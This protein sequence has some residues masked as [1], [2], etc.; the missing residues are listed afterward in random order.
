Q[1]RVAETQ[2]RLAAESAQAAEAEQRALA[3]DKTQEAEAERDRAET[4]TLLAQEQTVLALANSSKA[5][6]LADQPLEA[7]V[8]AVNAWQQVKIYRQDAQADAQAKNLDA[9]AALPVRAALMQGAYNDLAFNLNNPDALEAPGASNNPD[10]PDSKY[11]RRGFLEKNQLKAHS[12]RV[13][14]VAFSPDGNT[15][16]SASDDRTVKLWDRSPERLVAWSCGWLQDYLMH[17]PDGQNA[18]EEGVCEGYLPGR[19]GGLLERVWAVFKGEGGRGK[20]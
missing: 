20:G 13:R 12:A 1:A 15:I 7:L 16:A 3:E 4:Q 9:Q 2:Q 10:A 6:L 19:R 18:A 17:N 8:T 5:L 14:S 11:P